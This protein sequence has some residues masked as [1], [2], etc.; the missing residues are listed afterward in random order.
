MSLLVLGISLFVLG[1]S[2]SVVPPVD[3]TGLD[4]VFSLYF[5]FNSPDYDDAYLDNAETATALSHFL[6]VVAPERIDSVLVKGYASPEGVYENN[7]KVSR[8]RACRFEELVPERFPQMG[9]RYRL[10]SGGEA[11]EPLRQRI[12]A[13]FGLSDASRVR[14]LNILD[15]D[16]ISNDTKKWRLEHR[17][18]D[19]MWRY[20]RTNHFRY[21][22]RVEIRIF[23]HDI[24]DRDEPEAPDALDLSTEEDLLPAIDAEK[25]LEKEKDG[26]AVLTDVDQT[27]QEAPFPL[28]LP[29]KRFRPV[30]GVSTNLLYDVTY[31]PNYGFTSIPSFSVEY[32]PAAGRFTYGADVEW[33]MWQHPEDHRYLQIQHV[34]L[35]YRR[36]FKPL[37]GR[38]CGP[39]LSQGIDLARYGIGWDAKGWE[40]EGA[41]IFV[42]A[43]WKWTFGRLFIDVG[44]NLGFFYS[45][46]DPYVYGFDDA[47]WYYYD[48]NGDPDEFS[49]RRMALTWFGPTRVYFSVGIDLFN[50]KH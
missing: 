17:L 43:G 40:G 18:G 10:Q 11:W 34:A 31:V 23:Y 2:S 8:R 39:Y 45:K 7:V 16:S 6:E 37:P 50:R 9:G 14:V 48:Y 24:P 5:P 28:P 26:M 42:G 1:G 21:L 35:W 32:Y 12:V 30:L 46:Y 49:K 3:S 19:D 38:F 22:R 41:G 20:L 29:E 44:A 47:K 4:K 36:Y 13:D 27:S 33:P 15:D 25:E